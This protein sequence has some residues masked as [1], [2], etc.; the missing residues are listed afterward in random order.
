MARQKRIAVERT[1][2]D[3][4]FQSNGSVHVDNT[5]QNGSTVDHKKSDTSISHTLEALEDSQPGLGS[6]IFCVGGIYAS[7]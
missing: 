1:P 5:D 7:L 6:L 3:L 2:S 4:Y